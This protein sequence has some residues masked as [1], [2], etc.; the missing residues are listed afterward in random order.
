MKYEDFVGSHLGLEGATKAALTAS[1]WSVPIKG[2][3][4]SIF[5]TGT[6]CPWNGTGNPTIWNGPSRLYRST[7]Y[8]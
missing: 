1:G 2:T 6:D 5:P 4:A 3:G 8:K 7:V